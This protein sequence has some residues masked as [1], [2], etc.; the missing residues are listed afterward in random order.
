MSNYLSKE[1]GSWAKKSFP[2]KV[3]TKERGHKCKMMGT[4]SAKGGC[5]GGN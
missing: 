5:G 2:N 1:K 3:V 4:T